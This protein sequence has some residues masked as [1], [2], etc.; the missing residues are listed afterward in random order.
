[1]P[2]RKPPPSDSDLLDPDFLED[3]L[4]RAARG[5]YGPLNEV[6]AAYHQLKRKLADPDLSAKEL[7]EI[8]V[9]VHQCSQILTK[10][11]RPLPSIA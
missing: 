9:A 10:A 6:S 4:N 7:S 11:G 5:D 1:M 3:A 8:G 2:K